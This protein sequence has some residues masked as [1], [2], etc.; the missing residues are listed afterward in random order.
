MVRLVIDIE[1]IDGDPETVNMVLKTQRD[2]PAEV[3]EAAAR[4]LVPALCDLAEA[5]FAE[6]DEPGK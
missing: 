4:R 6:S 5:G 2:R 3:E 1:A